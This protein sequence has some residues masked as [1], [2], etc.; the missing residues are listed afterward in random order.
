MPSFTREHRLLADGSVAFVCSSDREQW[1]WLE[2][3]PCHPIAIQTEN[4]WISVECSAVR[5]TLDRD[6]WSALTF[7]RWQ[8]TDEAQG[9]PASGIMRPREEGDRLGFSI[10]LEAADGINCCTIEGE[11]VVFRHRD[12]A[13]WRG[14]ARAR[15]E[16]LPAC[17]RPV[18][19]AAP[20]DVGAPAGEAALISTLSEDGGTPCALALVTAENG[21]P[22]A[23]RYLTGSGDHV[24][25][26]HLAEAS[27]QFAALLR[28][29]PEL[30]ITGGELRFHRY[31][32]MGLAFELRLAKDS[33]PAIELEIA[34]GGHICA[35]AVLEL[36]DQ[37]L[38]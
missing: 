15:L 10:G 29:N 31:V 18:E 26:T 2:L 28:C 3:P 5:G 33:G 22:P 4:Y 24:N 34:Q 8:W 13:A 1:P 6:R 23:S 38:A 7:M 36:A 32:E 11:G 9:Q 17:Q 30:Q 21:L 20:A 35:H 16:A 19:F 37:G 27:R 12:F 25:A 14:Q